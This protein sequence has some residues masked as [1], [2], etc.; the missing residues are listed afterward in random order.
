MPFNWIHELW[1]VIGSGAIAIFVGL[2]LGQVQLALLLFFGFW[3][4]HY[5]YNLVRFERWLG[6]GKKFNPPDAAGLWG[7]VFSGIYNLQKRGRKRNKRLI[8]LVNR[9]RDT[10]AAMPDGV[11][12]MSALGEIEWWNE[13]AAGLLRLKYPQDVG[14]RLT[15]LVRNP[16]LMDYCQGIEKENEVIIPSPYDEETMLSFRMIS[17]GINQ[18][19]MTVRDVT[20]VEQVE[21]MRRDFVGNISHE[22]RTPLTVLSGYVEGMLDDLKDAEDSDKQLT[23]TLKVMQQQTRRMRQLT[24]DLMLLSNVENELQAQ[25]NEIINVPHMLASLREEGNI[26][27]G[28]KHHT[29]LLEA[30]PNL[31][32]RGDPKAL[33]SVFTNLVVNAI[34]Y[35]PAAG[36]IR[37]RWYEDAEGAHFE[38]NDTGIGIAQHHIKRLTERFYRVDVARSRNTGGSGLGLAIVKHAMQRHGGN[39]RIDSEIGRGSTFICDFPSEQVVHR[40]E[41]QQKSG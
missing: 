25:K 38:V 2:L 19:L 17:Y 39:L 13:A 28:D 36:A 14:Q 29:I 3:F 12:V 41:M 18:R 24:E 33:D 31:F 30:E 6:K 21:N 37:I 34:N 7:E 10:M 23:R 15:N 16:K 5:F 4:A 1:R 11:V 20:L 35:T 40:D 26:I 27:S 32:L 8:T 22:L 9:F